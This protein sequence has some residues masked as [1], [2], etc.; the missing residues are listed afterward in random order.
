MWNFE[1]FSYSPDCVF[2][3]ASSVSAHVPFRVCVCPQTRI[4]RVCVCP[5]TRIRSPGSMLHPLFQRKCL[6]N[7]FE[8]GNY[9]LTHVLHPLF[10]RKCLFGC[11]LWPERILN[12]CVLW[13][14]NT[15]VP[16]VLGH[17]YHVCILRFS[18]SASRTLSTLPNLANPIWLRPLSVWVPLQ[19]NGI[20]V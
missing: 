14:Q 6:S 8:W 2:Y 20:T 4:F 18:A 5:Q 1:F 17:R 13:V 19:R 11:V 16:Q 15:P 7:I 12:W 10:Q 9:F 3:V